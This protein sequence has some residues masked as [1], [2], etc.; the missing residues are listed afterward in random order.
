MGSLGLR[1]FCTFSSRGRVLLGHLATVALTTKSRRSVD[2]YGATLI[3]AFDAQVNPA[4]LR[5]K[6]AATIVGLAT[7]PF[8][9]NLP[10]WREQTERRIGLAERWLESADSI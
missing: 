10:R 1:C 6:V 9:V 5:R 7:G 8:R 3:R 2:R 4:A